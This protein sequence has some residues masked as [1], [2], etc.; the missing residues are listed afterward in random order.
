MPPPS[1][2]LLTVKKIALL[3]PFVHFAFIQACVLQS[4]GICLWSCMV[5]ITW[6]TLRP[7]TADC[8]YM[9]LCVCVCVCVCVCSVQSAV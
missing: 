7:L 2:A 9:R 4:G 6:Q 8:Q 1:P 3:S 5:A